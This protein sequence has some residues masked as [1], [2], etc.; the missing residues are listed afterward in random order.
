ML[1]SSA[2]KRSILIFALALFT[3]IAQAQTAP[4][5]SLSSYTRISPNTK[6][7]LGA[8]AVLYNGEIYLAMKGMGNEYLKISKTTD[9]VHVTTTEYTNITIKY[10]PSMVVFNNTLYIAYVDDRTASSGAVELLSTTDGSTL[11][12]AGTIYM[13]SGTGADVAA[14]GPPTL[15]EYGGT[16][17]AYWETD[18]TGY[19][20]N[21]PYSSYKSSYIRVAKM[22]Y[23]PSTWNVDVGPCGSQPAGALPTS[24]AALGA[25][26]F[27][28]KLYVAYQHSTSSGT[29]TLMVCAGGTTY[30]QYSGINPDGGI[31]A[32]VFDG[33]LYFAYKSNTSGNYL[34]LTG[35]TDGFNFT[36]P[37]TQYSAIRINGDSSY[38]IAPALLN[39]NNELYTFYT[40]NDNTHYL[41]MV[42]SN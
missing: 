17:Y 30:T 5:L 32:T 20:I 14:S 6:A 11:N 18:T 9:G 42:H 29:N 39:F 31:A 3:A 22:S 13:P 24:H 12:S 41:Y 37:G 15:V 27:N 40:A 36:E 10:A 19:D 33:S 1:I 35:T 25:A 2:S 28:D 21:Y 38:Q 7:G 8:S 4:V 16:L 23:D 34:E 26:V